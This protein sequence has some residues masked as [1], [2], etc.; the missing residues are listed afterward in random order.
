MHIPPNT[1][2]LETVESDQRR[3]LIQGSP[4]SGKTFAALTFPNPLV[5]NFDRGLTAHKGRKDVI[6]VPFWNQTFWSKYSSNRMDA[7]TSW[8]HQEASKL[9]KDQTLIFDGWTNITN[10]AD[11]ST[12]VPY[13]V[14][15]S[16]PDTMAWWGLRLK[17]NAAFCE[18]FKPLKCNVVMIC[19]EQDERSDEGDLTGN[20]KPLCQGSFKDQIGSHFTDLYRQLTFDKPKDIAKVPL[21]KFRMTADE[22]KKFV[23]SFPTPTMYLWQCR[24]DSIAKC[25]SSLIDPPHYMKAEWS[26]YASFNS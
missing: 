9:D 2:T 7:I 26:S 13:S 11:N 20:V 24:P 25:K 18:S 14:R 21:D 4:G 22:F 8:M 15:T 23:E 10:I 17:W 3:F 5:V 19:H 1:N 12:P 6:E 16:K